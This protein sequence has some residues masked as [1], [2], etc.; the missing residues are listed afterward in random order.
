MRRRL[1]VLLAGALAALAAAAPAGAAPLR[2]DNV[3]LLGKIPDSAGAIG[4][5]FSADGRT[6]FVTSATGLQIYDVSQP[7]TP[8]KLS[9]VPLPH[10]ENEDVD[11]GRNTVVITN[12][13]SFSNVGMIYL[14]DV[15]GGLKR[16]ATTGAAGLRRSTM[17]IPAPVPAR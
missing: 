15:I 2:S 8:R 3:T 13:P 9:Q 5:R 14:I 12:D 6:M 7:A 10:F 11:V 16:F 4:A 17:S 1:L